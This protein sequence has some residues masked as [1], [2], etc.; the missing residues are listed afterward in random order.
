MVSGTCKLFHLM[1]HIIVYIIIILML[2]MRKLRLKYLRSF[3]TFPKAN[4]M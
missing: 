1:L 2:K 3:S 4:N